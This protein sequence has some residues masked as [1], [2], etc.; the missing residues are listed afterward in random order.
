VLAGHLTHFA[1]FQMGVIYG[2]S[3]QT[4]FEDRR[5]LLSGQ[6]QLLVLLLKE[7]GWLQFAHV[8]DV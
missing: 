8:F 6:V 4:P 1:P 3:S 5:G 7:R 2:H